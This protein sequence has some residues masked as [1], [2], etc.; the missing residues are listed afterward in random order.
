MYRDFV[1]EWEVEYWPHRFKYKDLHVATKGFRD[2]QVLG[3]GGFGRVYKGVLPSNGLQIAVKRILRESTQGVKDF[4][5]EIS[6]LGRLQ[7]RNLVQ[8]RGYCKRGMHLFIVYDFMPNGS[9]DKLIF[10]N[11]D[12]VLKWA[13]RYKILTDVA[14]GLLYLHQGWDKIVVHRDIKSSN[15]LIDDKFNGKLGD[16]GLARLYEHEE[17]P[18]TTRLVGTLGYIA[19]EVLRTGKATPRSDVYSFG[20]V[21]LEVACGRRPV[22]LNVDGAQIL[23]VDWVRD[24]HANGRLIDAA[25]PN[26][27]GAYAEHEMD[28]VLRLGMVCCSEEPEARDDMRQVVQ[29]L[30]GEFWM[31]DLVPF[32]G[33]TDRESL[34]NDDIWRMMSSEDCT[35]SWSLEA[36]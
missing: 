27:G 25:D 29:I 35:A 14:E 11:P 30:E 15:I 21:M 9:L 28:R 6:S 8:I 4:I 5:A 24:L 23:L 13:Q 18:L 17:N 26:L 36:R 2:E 34:L 19:P 33:R 3:C 20:I 31:G 7:H 22:E 10:G 16:F 1:E 12:T 32:A